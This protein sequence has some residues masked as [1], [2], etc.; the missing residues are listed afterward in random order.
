MLGPVGQPDN[1]AFLVLSENRLAVS[2]VQRLLSAPKTPSQR[3]GTLI[4]PAGS[5]KSHLIRQLLKQRKPTSEKTKTL[6]VTASEFSAQLAD[7]AA[8]GAESQFQTRYRKDIEL[9]VVEDIQVLGPR[10]ETQQQLLA[11]LDDVIIQGAA[12]LLTTSKPPGEIAGLS[13]RLVN[14]IHGGVCIYVDLPALTSRVRLTEHLADGF[15]LTLSEEAQ[16]M[17]A[18][19]LESPREILGL[20]RRLCQSRTQLNG[21]LIA[22]DEIERVLDE[23]PHLATLSIAEIAQRVA[24]EFRLP[25]SELRGPRRSH[26]VLVPRQAA[27]YLSR[28]LGACSYTEIGRYFGGRNHNT[29]LY[30]CRRIEELIRDDARIA[31]LIESLRSGLQSLQSSTASETC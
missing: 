23:Q 26:A 1:H 19:R 9:L 12:C 24:R 14:R 10:R 22:E 18:A 29:V 13:R 27:M 7:A 5:G 16:E 6:V 3:L 30:A 28:E 21:K 4:G 25:L 15:Q 11:A 17:I 2:A 31:H 8:S 20:L